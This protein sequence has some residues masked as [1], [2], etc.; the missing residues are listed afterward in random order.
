MH[1]LIYI[2]TY[3]YII[4]HITSLTSKLSPVAVADESAIFRYELGAGYVFSCP[5]R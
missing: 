5:R 3:I 2:Y 1:V 4:P